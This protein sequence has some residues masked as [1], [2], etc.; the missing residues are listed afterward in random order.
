MNYIT[1]VILNHNS[2]WIFNSS[3][4]NTLFCGFFLFVFF[5]E[6]ANF[7]CLGSIFIRRNTA[8][9][10][11]GSFIF[12]SVRLWHVFQKSVSFS[13]SYWLMMHLHYSLQLV[14]IPHPGTSK[15]ICLFHQLG[16]AMLFRNKVCQMR[17]FKKK[18]HYILLKKKKK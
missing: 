16:Y 3:C 8:F 7:Q 5:G 10:D 9:V 6:W 14:Y 15:I 1:S 4:M 18:C 17:D 13:G 12:S 2:A 11:H